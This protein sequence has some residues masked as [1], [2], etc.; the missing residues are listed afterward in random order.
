MY[1]GILIDVRYKQITQYNMILHYLKISI[2]NLV[3]HKLNAIINIAGLAVSIAVFILIFR[4]IQNEMSTDQFHEKG[5]RIY[6]LEW[7]EFSSA[8][9]A[10]V[11]DLLMQKYPEILNATRYFP[12]RSVQLEYEADPGSG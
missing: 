4:Y 5:D 8:C 11:K 7:V 12:A 1:Y 10:G 2:R 6:R 3:R 9:S